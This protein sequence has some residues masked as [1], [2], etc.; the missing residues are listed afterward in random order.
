MTES[1]VP[2]YIT[3]AFDEMLRR[4]QTKL[5]GPAIAY[6]CIKLYLESGQDTFSSLELRRRYPRAVCELVEYSGHNIH[7]GAWFDAAYIS[8]EDRGVGKHGILK[9]LGGKR[10]KLTELY[11]DHAHALESWIPQRIKSFLVSKLGLVLSLEATPERVRLAEHLDKFV[12]FLRERIEVHDGGT[13]F[14]IVCFAIL[15]VYLDKFA[16]RI[17]RDTRTFSHE[18][19]T[20]ISTDFGAVFQIKKLKISRKHEVDKLYNEV[21]TNFDVARVQDGRVILIIDD[22]SPECRTYMVSK[23][24]LKYLRSTD[25]LDIATLIKESEDRQKV[26]RIVYEEI[27]REYSNDICARHG[28]D[29]HFCPVLKKVVRQ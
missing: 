22:I 23:N 5:I 27:T 11:R 24:A 12:D 6:T 8:R 9:P 26:L 10:Y 19:G 1:Y 16:C 25:M 29:G 14:E 4:A 2:Q 7:L 3:D 17:Y 18:G 21:T 15:K 28:C 13:S 20:D